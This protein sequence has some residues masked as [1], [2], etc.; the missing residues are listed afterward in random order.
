MKTFYVFV[1]V[2]ST[3]YITKVDSESAYNAEH[4]FLDRGFVG[5]HECS[6]SACQA[7]DV[8]GMK[9][10]TFV[11]MAMN[12]MPMPYVSVVGRICKRNREI[13]NKDRLERL[14]EEITEMEQK[15]EELKKQREELRR[16]EEEEEED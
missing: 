7:F 14:N 1:L 5:R 9:T 16:T 6:V 11:G 10:D 13:Q 3:C 8:E 15:L 12:A 2:N 4:K